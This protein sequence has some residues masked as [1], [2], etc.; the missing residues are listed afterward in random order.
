MPT[1][2]TAQD[3]D[4]LCG[5][6]QAAGFLDC[7]PLRGESANSAFLNR[8]LAAGD[9]V[10]IPDLTLK[11]VT[12]GVEKVHNFQIKNAPPPLADTMGELKKDLDALRSKE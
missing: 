11:E 3:G 4:T 6:A 2:V 1:V 5:L 7:A 10:T 8:P 9:L 12:K